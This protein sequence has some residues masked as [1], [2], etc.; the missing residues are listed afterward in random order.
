MILCFLPKTFLLRDP[1][2]N[3]VTGTMTIQSEEQIVDVH[4]RC[5]VYS[6][7]TIFDYAR[8]S[9]SKSLPQINP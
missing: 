5:G 7:D 2:S 8:V 1:V 3:Y 4:V 6:S 9:K